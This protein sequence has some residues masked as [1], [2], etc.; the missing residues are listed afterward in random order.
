MGKPSTAAALRFLLRAKVVRLPAANAFAIP[1]GH[2]YVFEGLIDKG[3]HVRRARRRHCPR[4]GRGRVNRDGRAGHCCR[5][6]PVVPVRHVLGGGGAAVI[7]VR[8]VLQ[9]SYSRERES[10]ADAYGA[11][12]V[13]KIG[14]DPRTL[15]AIPLPVAGTPGA[16]TNILLTHPEANGRAIAID[17]PAGD[18]PNAAGLLAPAEWTA[19]KDI[20]GAT[21]HPAGRKP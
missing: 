16:F 6:P 3:E 19:L 15:G 14:G 8:T 2:V 11:R 9:S 20:C 18:A 12:L 13:Q 21:T 5:T 1:G 7:G 17:A 4:D 10:A